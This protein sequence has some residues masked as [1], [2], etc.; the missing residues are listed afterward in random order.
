MPLQFL[1]NGL[2][3]GKIEASN[4]IISLGTLQA[5]GSYHKRI[6]IFRPDGEPFKVLNTAI[7]QATTSGINGTATQNLDGSYELIVS[8]TL[9]F[10]PKWPL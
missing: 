7:L 8:G 6:R 4:H 10:Y 1:A 3:Y 5:G 2:T 9:S